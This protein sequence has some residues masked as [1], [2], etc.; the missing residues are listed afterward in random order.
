MEYLFFNA[1]QIQDHD[2]HSMDMTPNVSVRNGDERDM[3]NNAV[4]SLRKMP[5][6][7]LNRFL[8]KI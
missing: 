1:P 5:V 2:R 6:F 3:T 4:R 8:P 7:L